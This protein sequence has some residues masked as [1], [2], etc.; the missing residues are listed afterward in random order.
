MKTIVLFFMSLLWGLFSIAQTGSWTVY[1]ISNSDLPSNKIESLAF[2]ADGTWIGTYEGGVAFFD[3]T[4]WTI[5]SSTNSDLPIDRVL[6]IAING[7]DKWFGTGWGLANLDAAGD[8]TVY[9]TSGGLPQEYVSALK[10]DGSGDLLV[11]TGGGG[12][13]KYDIASDTWTTLLSGQNVTDIDIDS[14]GDLWISTYTNGVYY[15]EPDGTELGHYTSTNSDLPHNRVLAIAVDGSDNKWIGCHWHGAAKLASDNSTWT[16]YNETNSDL[17]DNKV[18]S[19]DMDSDT[20]FAT[21]DGLAEFDGSNWTIYNTGNSTIP[22]NLVEVIRIDSGGDKW[23][24]TWGGGLAEYEVLSDDLGITAISS[25]SSGVGLTAN[26]TVTVTITNFGNNAQAGFDVSYTIDGGAAVTENVAGPIASGATLDYSFTTTADL[27]EY[28]TYSIEAYTEL[29]GDENSANDDH[30]VSVT[31]TPPA[32]ALTGA[33]QDGY[34]IDLTWDAW[35]GSGSIDHFKVYRDGVEIGTAGA[36]TTGYTDDDDFTGGVTYEYYITAVKGSLESGHSDTLSATY[37]LYYCEPAFNDPMPREHYIDSVGFV[38][39]HH[40]YTG[41]T[42]SGTDYYNDYTDTHATELIRGNTYTLEVYYKQESGADNADE[43]GVWFDWDADGSFTGAADSA[44]TGSLDMTGDSSLLTLMVNVPANAT[45]AQTHMRVINI[46]VDGTPIDPC[47]DYTAG[48]NV[49]SG[50]AEDYAL[51]IVDAPST[52]HWDFDGGNPADPTYTIYFQDATLDGTNL[53]PYD[54][55]AVY[56]NDTLVGVMQLTQVCTDDNW[57]ENVLIAFSTIDETGDGY[58]PGNDVIF[59]CWDFSEGEEHT[60]NEI[61]YLD[62]AGDAWTS[63]VFPS[64]DG[65]YSIIESDFYNTHFD[66]VGGNESENTWT[67]YIWDAEIDDANIEQYDEVAIFDGSKMVGHLKLLGAFSENTTNHALTA[68]HKLIDGTTGYT[69]ENPVIYK[70]WDYS[71]GEEVIYYTLDTHAENPGTDYMDE[72][73]PSGDGEVSY[74]MIDATSTGNIDTQTINLESGYQFASTYINPF[75]PQDYDEIISDILNAN[76]LQFVR[77]DN[78]NMLHKIGPSWINNIGDWITTEGYLYKMYSND[79]VTVN[80]TAVDPTSTDVPVDEGYSFISYLRNSQMDALTAFGNDADGVSDTYDDLLDDDTEFIR[81][82]DGSILHKIGATWVNGIGNLVPGEGYLVKRSAIAPSSDS[83]LYFDGSDDYMNLGD[84]DELNGTSAFTISFWM[85]DDDNSASDRLF[86]K[87]GDNTLSQDI[88]LA[89]HTDEFYVEIGNGDNSFGYWDDYATTL[90]SGTWFHVATVFDGSQATNDERLKL[91]I[92]GSEVTL[93]YSGTIPATTYDLSGKDVFVSY[94]DGAWYYGGYLDEM[95][96]WNTARTETQINNDMVSSL[97]GNEPGLAGYWKLDDGSG[98]TATDETSNG[99]D[100][101]ITGATWDG[102]TPSTSINFQYPANTKSIVSSVV[103]NQ[104][105]HFIFKGGNPADP[106]YT[107]YIQPGN[108]VQ[109][110]DEVAAFA[111]GKLV[112]STVIYSEEAYDNAIA[113]FSTLN[114]GDGYE[115]GDELRLHH[116]DHQ[117]GEIST[118]YYQM[119]DVY[120]EAYTGSAYPE[121]DGE[122]SIAKVTKTAA[123]EKAEEA[124]FTMYPN[125]A[126]DKIFINSNVNIDEVQI[127]NTVG[128]LV[129]QQRIGENQTSIKLHTLT[130]GLYIV[131]ITSSDKIITKKLIVK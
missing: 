119:S 120:E 92:N 36:G 45:I 122:Y 97:N 115:A 7:D 47:G 86:H 35:A 78:G 61:T 4:T 19:I 118:L 26:E 129:M 42:G 15:L 11:G 73:F 114:A 80:G 30:T 34:D 101:S 112:G 24:G 12:L 113:A 66:F 123:M 91:Y 89:T 77:N 131:Q 59:K 48:A 23:A 25:P 128:K 62:P 74:H 64:G 127:Y 31:N 52:T 50:E 90:S 106:V 41:L 58:T 107:I 3:G 69:S 88:S 44:Y 68:Y 22:S 17:P 55:I 95:R 110:G 82:S 72:V 65:E 2:N 5:Y 28:A 125:P 87:L 8:W 10:F 116:W 63:S 93:T 27:S 56:D 51:N 1:D 108:D 67:I 99:Y 43:Y 96:V 39:I 102:D 100:G 46:A 84:I 37:Q 32:P 16:V 70:L 40:Y 71:A 29:A 85:K 109:P 105:Q 103:R 33:A 104:P 111:G 49:S 126:R 6:S 54:E 53:M 9:H 18:N 124:S 121:T 57:S 20:W 60:L 38:G 83:S 81:D 13:A 75:D 117:T 79:V 21:D 98:T 14:G 94:P 130:D 76:S